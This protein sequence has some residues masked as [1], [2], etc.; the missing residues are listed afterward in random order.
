MLKLLRHKMLNTY[1]IKKARE[2]Q[3]FLAKKY[4][5]KIGSKIDKFKNSYKCSALQFIKLNYYYF[6]SFGFDKNK[7]LTRI[8]GLPLE[9]EKNNFHNFQIILDYVRYNKPLNHNWVRR[10]VEFIFFIDSIKRDIKDHAI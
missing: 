7:I 4:L 1:Q 8:L 6:E 5:E 10:N 2:L 3:N 9:V